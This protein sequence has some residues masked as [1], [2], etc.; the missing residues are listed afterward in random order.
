MPLLAPNFDIADMFFALVITPDFYMHHLE[1]A[2]P[3]PASGSLL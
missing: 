3:D 2:D 1:V